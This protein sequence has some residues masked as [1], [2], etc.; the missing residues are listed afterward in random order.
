MDSYL[1]CHEFKPS[2]TE[3]SSCRGG[4]CT[5]DCRGSHMLYLMW[6]GDQDRRG[7]RVSQVSSS[8]L[9]HGS[10]LRCSLKN[11]PRVA[12]ECDAN[13]FTHSHAYITRC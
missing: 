1:E 13:V 5:L 3:D 10:K 12:K 6:C 2:A 11:S 7:G 8:S 4:R 9:D